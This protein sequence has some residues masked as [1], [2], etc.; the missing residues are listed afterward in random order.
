MAR[1]RTHQTPGFSVDD[2]LAEL[3]PRHVV[4]WAERAVR[5]ARYD[6]VRV[7]RLDEAEESAAWRHVREVLRRATQRPTIRLRMT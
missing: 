7:G 6:A 2:Y 3:R 5:I 1:G 4:A